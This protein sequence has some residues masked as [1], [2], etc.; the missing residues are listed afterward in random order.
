MTCLHHSQGKVYS[1][2]ENTFPSSR[3]GYEQG[4]LDIACIDCQVCKVAKLAE[5]ICVVA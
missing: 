4:F 3:H 5:S 2:K 1:P